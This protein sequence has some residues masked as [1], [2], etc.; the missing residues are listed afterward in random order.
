LNALDEK[1]F[2]LVARYRGRMRLVVKHSDESGEFLGGWVS[3]R[4][5]T[6]LFVRDGR[7]VA[8]MIGDLPAREIEALIRSA[9][10]ASARLPAP[11]E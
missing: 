2:D 1:L 9:L 6:V 5:P 4:S 3:G 11:I 10:P 8:E 7:T